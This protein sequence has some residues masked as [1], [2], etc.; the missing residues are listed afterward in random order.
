MTI[1]YKLTIVSIFLIAGYFSTK[2]VI[3]KFDNQ[4]QL[5]IDK[6]KIE[7]E[8]ERTKQMELMLNKHSELKPI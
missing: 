6:N 4:L 7:L 5:E 1:F 3:K 2:I 8:K